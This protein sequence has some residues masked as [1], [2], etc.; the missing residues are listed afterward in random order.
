MK[1]I[2]YICLFFLLGSIAGCQKSDIM[3]YEQRAGVYFSTYSSSYSF[4]DSPGVDTAV[5]RL[6]VDI[7]GST[8]DYDREFIITLPN[9]DT[10]T[11]AEDDQYKIRKGIVKAG[12]GKGF[13]EV[14]LYRD[15]RLK[16]STYRI[17]LS[18]QRSPDFPEIRLKRFNMSVSFTER[19]IRPDNWFQLKALG[20]YSTAWWRFILSVTEGNRLMYWGGPGASMNPDPEKWYMGA[21]ELAAWVTVIR[22]A[23]DEYNDGPDGPLLHDD[24]DK[25]G[26]PVKMPN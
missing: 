13:V 5:L 19:L 3:L 18:I 25:K 11:T 16:D 23:L 14:E 20:D 10:L 15:D 4:A 26:E 22:I 6:P 1:T 2:K 9:V 21:A 12:E 24:G 8:T 7:T 17:L